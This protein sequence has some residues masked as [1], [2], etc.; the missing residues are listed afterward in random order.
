MS[1]KVFQVL[2]DEGSISLADLSVK[3]GAQ[4]ALLSTPCDRLIMAKAD[5]FGSATF[6]DGYRVSTSTAIGRWQLCTHKIQSRICNGSRSRSCFQLAVSSEYDSCV[7]KRASLRSCRYD[8]VFLQLCRFHLYLKEKGAKEP[9]S[10]FTS[11]FAWTEGQEGKA[12]WE[13]M[14]QHPE[15]FA[16]FQ[17]GLPFYDANLPKTGYYDFGKLAEG[18]DPERVVMVDIGCGLGQT[19]ME[20]VK[21]NPAL[22]SSKI[23]LQDLANVVEAATEGGNLPSNFKFMV[24]DFYTPQ[25]V[26]GKLCNH[27]LG[28]RF[29]YSVG[30]QVQKHTIYG[31]CSTTIRTR[32]A[33]RSCSSW[34]L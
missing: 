12:I 23:V 29:T 8:E 34:C 15:R 21:A 20:I 10:Q 32:F 18:S 14:A 17:R 26:N 33:C 30:A 2:P 6:A 7:A 4:E 27:H 19:M 13:I 24:H 1:L 9:D 11:P 31:V 5:L 28:E 25:P 3:T 22:S 16:T